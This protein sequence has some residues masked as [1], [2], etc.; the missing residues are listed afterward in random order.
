MWMALAQNLNEW[1][2]LV[3]EYQALISNTEKLLISL[4][5][6]VCV[7]VTSTHSAT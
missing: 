3:M 6:D 2:I 1:R 4:F 5:I 7:Y